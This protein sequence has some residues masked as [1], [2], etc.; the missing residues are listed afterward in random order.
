M[1]DMS[2]ALYDNGLERLP[3]FCTVK[4]GGCDNILERIRGHLM[5]RDEI[6]S[7]LHDFKARFGDQYGIIS[8][9]VF[10][11]VAHGEVREDSDVDLYVTTKTPNPFTLVHVKDQIEN[12]LC[13]HVDIIRVR[14]KMNPFLK[15]RIEEEGIYV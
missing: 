12:G 4:G 14:E 1:S 2:V 3:G 9:G 8:L 13:R 6:L 5:N 11:S 7:F 10:G 15:K